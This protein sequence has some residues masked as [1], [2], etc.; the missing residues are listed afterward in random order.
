MARFAVS[1]VSKT[2]DPIADAYGTSDVTLGR[3]KNYRISLK[4]THGSNSLTYHVVGKRIGGGTHAEQ[5][6]IA[7]A[8]LAF[9][10]QVNLAD[11]STLW[12]EVKVKL[13]NTVG[14]NPASATLEFIH[15][16]ADKL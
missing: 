1:E 2:V 11:I 8:A 13:K 12:G 6:I 7:E 14:G 9:G 10:V 4:N 15:E 5:E 3:G 16:S